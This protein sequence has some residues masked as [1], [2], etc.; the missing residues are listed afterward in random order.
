MRSFSL[1]LSIIVGITSIVLF[2]EQI[3][4][5]VVA[6]TSDFFNFAG[7]I[8][9]DIVS[10][11]ETKQQQQQ[12]QQYQRHHQQNQ[13]DDHLYA[14]DMSVPRAIHK[15]F[16][17]VEQA[18]GAGARVRRSIGTPQLRNLSPFLMLGMFSLSPPP[19]GH[20]RLQTLKVADIRT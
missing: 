15:V 18:E 4:D 5:L 11:A 10:E 13:P 6:T 3:F 2:R 9:N 16:L 1:L 7:A 17:A 14:T 19:F 8:Q 20:S 12:Q